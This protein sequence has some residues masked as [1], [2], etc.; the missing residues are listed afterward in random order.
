LG[1]PVTIVS[2]SF[3]A[4]LEGLQ[5]FDYVN[6]VALPIATAMGLAPLVGIVLGYHLPG[7]VGLL[8]AIRTLGL[9]C[10]WLLALRV[11]LAIRTVALPD[12][13]AFKSLLAFGG[14]IA[15][16]NLFRPLTTSV[17]RVILTRWVGLGAVAYYSTAF[18]L[19]K[20]IGVITSSWA[21]AA[22]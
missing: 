1:A 15:A 21:S 20:R 8:V 13:Q 4:L 9:L 19:L 17:D 10:Y 11:N 16:P 3:R 5:Y 2:G 6:L 7:I 22:F 14:Y 18:D 12:R